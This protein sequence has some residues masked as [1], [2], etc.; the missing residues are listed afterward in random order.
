MKK[1]TARLQS[2]VAEPG[3]MVAATYTD[4]RMVRADLSGLAA[5]H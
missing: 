3:M 4:G 1:Q 5:Q 2:V